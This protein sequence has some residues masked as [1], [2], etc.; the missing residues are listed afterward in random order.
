MKKINLLRL[1]DEVKFLPRV[2]PCHAADINGIKG[3]VDD[4]LHIAHLPLLRAAFHMGGVP[5]SPVGREGLVDPGVVE[6]LCIVVS[7]LED[8]V[9]V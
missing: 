7:G 4:I 9:L 1:S 8:L 2:Q 3:H 6:T 5:A